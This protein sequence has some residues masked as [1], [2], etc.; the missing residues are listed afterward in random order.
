MRICSC[1]CWMHVHGALLCLIDFPQMAILNCH[2]L[3]LNRLIFKMCTQILFCFILSYR[4]VFQYLWVLTDSFLQQ[5]VTESLLCPRREKIY[6]AWKPKIVVVTHWHAEFFREW[7]LW[8]S[9]FHLI[10]FRMSNKSCMWKTILN[11]KLIIIYIMWF[12]F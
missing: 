3:K 1:K 6:D 9:V 10:V 11:V 7:L 4:C 8:T 5:I 12:S 2:F